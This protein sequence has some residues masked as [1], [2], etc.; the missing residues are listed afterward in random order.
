MMTVAS[1][2]MG[3]RPGLGA[4]GRESGSLRSL[5]IVLLTAQ[6]VN[7]V[8]AARGCR[9]YSSGCRLYSLYTSC[10]NAGRAQFRGLPPIDSDCTPAV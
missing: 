7:E 10:W 6:V 9:L 5:D 2:G 8:V 1:T 3:S 4:E